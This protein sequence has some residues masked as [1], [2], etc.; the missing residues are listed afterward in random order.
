M[1][2]HKFPLNEYKKAIVIAR[3]QNKYKSIKVAFSYE[4]DMEGKVYD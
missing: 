1:V 2:T 3:A 4:T